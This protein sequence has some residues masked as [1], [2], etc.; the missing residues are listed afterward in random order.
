[1]KTSDFS[2][3]LPERL[4]A[5]YPSEQRGQSRLMLLDRVTR[6]RSHHLVEELPGLLTQP[7][8]RGADD[9]PPLLVFNNSKVRKA[10]LLAKS[11]QTGGQTEFLLLDKITEDDRVWKVMA[12]RA[13]RRRI[14]SSY[15]FYDAVGSETAAARISGEDG[16]FRI[17]EFDRPIDD[18]WLEKYGH[19]PLPPYI[20]R[21]DA[22]ADAERYQTV[23]ARITGSAAAPTAGLH[24]TGDLLA[25]LADAG[26]ERAFVTLHV[27]LGT[28]LPVRVENIEDHKMHEER[29]CID[30]ENA[31]KIEGAKEAGRK[32]VAV[33][34]TSVRTLES[35]WISG[36][37]RLRRGDQRTS[38]FIYPG[39][40]FQITDALFTNFHTPESTLLMLVSAFAETKPVAFAE[41]KTGVSAGR[42]L[43]LESY[44]EAIQEG[45]HFFSYGDAMLLV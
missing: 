34:T 35:A 40:R 23:Y 2:F 11:V 18:A 39:C 20:K 24:F 28:F 26:I 33:G 44:A 22:P 13:K 15:V 30:E 1:M 9:S 27:G 45:Y 37:G 38:I 7:L 3:E 5:Q 16:E 43:I 25:R 19:I 10:R 21:A 4:V 14:G 31:A 41:G 6:K 29:F 12:Q 42:E 32:I 17:L 36:E 8:F